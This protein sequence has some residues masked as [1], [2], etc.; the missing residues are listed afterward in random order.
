MVPVE[1][2]LLRAHCGCEVLEPNDCFVELPHRAA[3]VS[4][5]PRLQLG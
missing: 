3:P 1:S 2:F 4:W 5:G